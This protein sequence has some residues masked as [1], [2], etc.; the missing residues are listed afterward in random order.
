MF[1]GSIVGGRKGPGIF[2]EKERGTITSKSY[3]IHILLEIQAFIQTNPSL[4]FM[5]DNA[6]THRSKLTARN[7]LARQIPYIK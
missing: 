6:P 3:N 7:L 1:H 5:Q 2:W 4:I